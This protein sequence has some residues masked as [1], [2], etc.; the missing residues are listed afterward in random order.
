MVRFTSASLFPLF[1][2][3]TDAA[4]NI[5]AGVYEPKNQITDLAALDLDQLEINMQLYDR[6]VNN[7]MLVYQ[8]GAHS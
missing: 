2:T 5:Y 8:E 1:A 6:K 4:Y 7:A 3:V